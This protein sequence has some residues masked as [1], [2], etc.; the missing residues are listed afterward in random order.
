MK[1][2]KN[3]PEFSKVKAFDEM[4]LSM[5]TAPNPLP[6][7]SMQSLINGQNYLQK[8]YDDAFAQGFEKGLEATKKVD[9]L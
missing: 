9:D 4:M 8:I 5:Q 7:E 2:N 1:S 6:S 3:Q